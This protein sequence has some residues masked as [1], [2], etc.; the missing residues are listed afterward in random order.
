MRK[1]YLIAALLTLSP[2]VCAQ[3]NLQQPAP[4]LPSEIVG[5]PLV[6]WSATQQ[7][8]PV[9]ADPQPQQPSVQIF[10]GT[11]AQDRGKYMLRVSDTMV[12][13][14]GDQEMVKIYEGKQVRVAAN[15]DAQNQ[16]LHITRIDVLS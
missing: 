5:P 2:F 3:D 14:L 15:L 6:V 8:R 1:T 12:Y 9:S 13:Q 7:P 10:T 11:I 4:A 16:V